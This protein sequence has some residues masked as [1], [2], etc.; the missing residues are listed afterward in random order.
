MSERLKLEYHVQVTGLG[1]ASAAAQ[2]AERSAKGAS[3]AFTSARLEGGRTLP[4]VL[5]GVRAA[6]AA[7]LAVEQTGK[8]ISELD[9]RSAINGFMNMLQVTRNLTSLMAL[10]KEST[11]AASAAQAVLATLTGRWW[12]VPLAL[13]AGAMVYSRLQSMHTGGMVAETGPYLLHKGEYV[14]PSRNVRNFGPIFVS[15]REAP[16]SGL[17][18]DVWLQSLGE[19]VERRTR[20][21]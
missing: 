21:S 4:T 17:D 2:S 19:Q 7:R 9:P 8:A 15:V 10:L 11:G 3:A 16:G 20:R 12:L 6:N 1:E 5:M 14:V 13:T 18:R